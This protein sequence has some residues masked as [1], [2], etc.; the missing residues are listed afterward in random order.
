M[1]LYI[2]KLLLIPEDMDNRVRDDKCSCIYVYHTEVVYHIFSHM[3]G[4]YHYNI[5]VHNY[6]CHTT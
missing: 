3:V 6:V 1:F 4:S 5:S 2:Y